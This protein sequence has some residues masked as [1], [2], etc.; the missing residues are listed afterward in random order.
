MNFLKTVG[1]VGLSLSCSAVAMAAQ[2]TG[3]APIS[4]DDLFGL[5]PEKA[6]EPVAEDLKQQAPMVKAPLPTSKEALF[7]DEPEDK[8]AAPSQSTEAMLATDKPDAVLPDSK[9]A[10]FDE[11]LMPAKEPA[12]S[13]VA[14]ADNSARLRGTFQTEFARTLANPEHGTKLLGRLDLSS[15]GRLQG[16]AQW[17]LSGR[18]NYNAIYDIT[19]HYQPQVR[20]D[21]R[22]EFELRE[23]YL[24]FSAG[25]LEW[26][27]GRQNVVWGE[28][29]GMF[30]ADVV[31]AKDLREFILPDFQVLRIPQWAARTEYFGDDFHVEALWIPFPSYDKI[32][33]PQDFAN[34][35]G[36]GADF[37]PYPPVA[38]PFT[39][40]DEVKPSNSLKHTNFGVRLS[41]LA[42]GWD[43]S[44]FFYTSMNNAATFYRV[45]PNVYQ[46]RHDRIWQLGGSLAKD[47]G[48]AVLKAE[49][50]Y[51]HGR[52]FNLQT[53]LV[54]VDG[55][56]KLPMLDWAVGLDFNPDTDTR[57][58]VQFVQSVIFDHDA[59]ILPDRVEN[60]MS[61]LVSR[62]L[63]SQW[64]AELLVLSSLNRSDWLIRPK[65][66]WNFQPNWKA[67]L[68]VDVFHG[69]ADGYFGQFDQQDRVYVD[70]RYDF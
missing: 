9:A 36:S 27:L 33:K 11:P 6:S 16:G 4:K 43:M 12:K 60:G 41:Q 39:L 40:L 15:Q 52:R 20:D 46:P 69:P 8:A 37:Y 58:N 63:S 32:G 42:D 56:V 59:D 54:D 7:A 18:V 13:A 2:S 26:R 50:V 29:V 38:F 14:A 3:D 22:L 30:L 35:K 67:T 24:D 28:M 17:K 1:V 64:R 25:N 62:A 70:V 53:N 45:A 44:G 51:T 66:T 31:S 48:P 47:L 61:F 34:P 23:N 68:G 5:G 57:M 65:A 19:N 55:V 10:L 21:Q 49:A